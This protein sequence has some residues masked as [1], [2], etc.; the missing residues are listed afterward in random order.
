MSKLEFFKPCFNGKYEI[1]NTG[2]V[3]RIKSGRILKPSVTKG[4]LRLTLSN[5]PFRVNKNVHSLV[6]EAF[7]GEKPNGLIINHI[8]GIK[9]DNR[10]ENLEYVTY[11]HNRLHAIKNNLSSE[12]PNKK[13]TENDICF[14][15]NL[16][17]IW[18]RKTTTELCKKYNVSRS[19]IDFIRT[20]RRYG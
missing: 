1:S 8:N 3:R 13:L 11:K 12:S 6:A 20:G 19:C 9:T 4:Y 10:I 18:T 16:I 14:I 17:P 2:Q 15:K 7:I 5:G